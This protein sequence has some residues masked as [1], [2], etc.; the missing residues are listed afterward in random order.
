MKFSEL[1]FRIYLIGYPLLPLRQTKKKP[2]GYI[3]PSIPKL[4]RCVTEVRTMLGFLSDLGQLAFTAFSCN[5]WMKVV[6]SVIVAFRLSFPLAELPDWDD[7]WARSELRFDEFLTH[8]CEGSD[9][10]TV[11]TRVDAVS[12][13]R[14][15]LRVVKDKYDRRIALHANKAAAAAETVEATSLSSSIRGCPMSDHRMEPYISSWDTRFED[16]NAIPPLT[17]H[18]ENEQPVLHDMWATMTAEW[19]NDT[20]GNNEWYTGPW[21]IILPHEA[22]SDLDQD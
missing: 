14:V 22:S 17:Q 11:N 9:L 7:A 2:S 10:I 13:C 4:K 18:A 8:M 15:V 19:A 6:I 16:G 1:F 3:F 5:D 20:I 21:D 12:A